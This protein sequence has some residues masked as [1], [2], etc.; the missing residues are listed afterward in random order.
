MLETMLEDS[1]KLKSR[2]EDDY[3]NLYQ[4]NLTLENDIKKLTSDAGYW[5]FTNELKV[6]VATS[7]TCRKGTRTNCA[8]TYYGGN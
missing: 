6:P 2:F 7:I 8:E 1:N 3:L 5:V 4:R